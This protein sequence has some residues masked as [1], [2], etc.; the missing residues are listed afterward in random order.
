MAMAEPYAR[1][2]TSMLVGQMAEVA[3]FDVA[4]G[5]AIDAVA[6][7]MLRFIQELGRNSLA[8]AE[9]QGR[10][11]VNALDLVDALQEFGMDCNDL[12]QFAKEE[13]ADPFLHTVAP[14][15]VYRTALQPP[16]FEQAGTERP[17][18]IPA[19]LPAFPAAHTMQFTPIQPQQADQA[20]AEQAPHEPSTAL[21]SQQ[22]LI[23]L[24]QKMQA[25]S[26]AVRPNPF[27]ALQSKQAAEPRDRAHND[28]ASAPAQGQGGLDVR[29]A[30]GPVLKQARAD[31]EQAAA[32]AA[33]AGARGA[34][35]TS[36][37]A[38]RDADSDMMDIDAPESPGKGRGSPGGG[39]DSEAVDVAAMREPDDV[40]QQGGRVLLSL[41]PAGA[42]AQFAMR[43]RYT[44]SAQDAFLKASDAATTA[45]GGSR[46]R[47]A[48]QDPDSAKRAR[49]QDILAR[50]PDAILM[51]Y[52][53]G[54]VPR[55][56]T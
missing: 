33:P 8:V 5:N 42:C 26:A 30:F 14:F 56:G 11:D 27:L 31:S 13:P 6:D 3:G 10:T 25:S 52:P 53:E 35:G 21:Q 36:A 48:A 22:A 23:R 49:A 38:A 39:W 1:K 7:V 46:R 17:S 43:E 24:Q 12:F 55:S 40:L 19:H 4:H 32:A 29:D 2:V 50:G 41:D 18:H 37:A 16:T 15:P 9:L 44:Q 28:D 20:T 34:A 51:E 54:H 47:G 45:G